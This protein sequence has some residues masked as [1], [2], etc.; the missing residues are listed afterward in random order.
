MQEIKQNL[1]NEKEA[2]TF[3]GISRITLLRKRQK[4]EITFFRIGLRVLYSK[5]QH[6]I[7]FLKKCETTETAKA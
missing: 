5:E 7:P 6:L 2:A 3:L 4:G 1:M